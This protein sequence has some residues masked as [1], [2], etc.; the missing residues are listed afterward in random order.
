MK[1]LIDEVFDEDSREQKLA[2]L[3]RAVPG[4]RIASAEERQRIL[5]R[6]NAEARRE[7]STS[8][9]IW[10]PAAGHRTLRPTVGAAVLLLS[11]VVAAASAIGHSI[12]AKSPPPPSVSTPAAAPTASQAA[13]E[14]RPSGHVLSI[15]DD[16]VES[17]STA[18]PTAEAPSKHVKLTPRGAHRSADGEDASEVLDAIRA[19]RSS[20]DAVRAGVL[21]GDYLRMHPR[22]VLA[23]DA[24]ALSLEAAVARHDQRSAAQLGQRYLAQ[25]PNGR[26]RPFVTE[27]L[28]KI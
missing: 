5:Y 7:S 4:R 20:G 10:W 24:L 25:F 8:F 14:R 21:L 19:L 16:G 22:G 13:P 6:V 2:D 27:T 18:S 23:E 28:S 3:V 15:P 9:R 11:G 26:Y 12:M 17:S 1:R